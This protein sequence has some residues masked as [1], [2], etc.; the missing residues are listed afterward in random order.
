MV[1][2]KEPEGDERCWKRKGKEPVEGVAAH[3]PEMPFLKLRKSTFNSPEELLDSFVGH[4]REKQ[5][6]FSV[7]MTSP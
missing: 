2:G 6:L 4:K 5:K 7:S 3:H 1:S